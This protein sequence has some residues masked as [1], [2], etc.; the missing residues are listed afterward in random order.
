MDRPPVIVDLRKA[1]AKEDRLDISMTLAVIIG[2]VLASSGVFIAVVLPELFAE[3]GPGTE[4]RTGELAV[5]MTLTMD[6]IRFGDHNLSHAPFQQV[7]VLLLEGEGTSGTEVQVREFAREMLTILVG[8]GTPYRLR[9]YTSSVQGPPWELVSLIQ[10]PS[11]VDPSV[12]TIEFR[13]DT[14]SQYQGSMT[15]TLEIWSRGVQ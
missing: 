5:L 14:L 11:D 7:L 6:E 15:V 10:L 2:V 13:S 3:E 4:D 12:Q 1:E 8:E 9:A